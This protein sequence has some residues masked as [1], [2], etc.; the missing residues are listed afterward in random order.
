[1]KNAVSVVKLVGLDGKPL[2]DVELPGLGTATNLIGLEDDDEAYFQFSSFTLPRQ[3]FKTQVKTGKSEL[4]AKVDVP[5]DPTPYV[6]E[7]VW[8]PSKDGTKVSMFLVHRKDAQKNG[9]NPTLMYAY[10]GF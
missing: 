5:V 2:R 3:V 7:Q 9:Q 10:G 8:Y 6:V 1:E 4:W